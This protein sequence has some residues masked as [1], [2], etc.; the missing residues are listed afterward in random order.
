MWQSRLNGGVFAANA[1]DDSFAV[2]DTGGL[3]N[4]RV[5]Y[6]NRD[7]GRTNARGLLLVPELRAFDLNHIG[8]EATDVPPDVTLET[9]LRIV[10]PPDHAGVIV[11]FPAQASHGA[12]LILVD[13]AGVA[14]PIGSTATVRQSGAIAPVG[15]DG[16]TYVT[17]LQPHNMIDVSL[18]DGSLCSLSFDY[19]PKAGDLPTVGPLSCKI[20]TK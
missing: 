8:I 7:V 1:I 12:L 15:F 4:I 20:P 3:P 11:R 13:A 17:G 9:D 10:R 14:I 18:P 6:E 19:Q 2:V 16:E 5:L